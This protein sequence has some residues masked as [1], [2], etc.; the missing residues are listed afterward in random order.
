MRARPDRPADQSFNTP[1][2]REHTSNPSDVTEPIAEWSSWTRRCGS[3]HLTLPTTRIAS[4]CRSRSFCSFPCAQLRVLACRAVPRYSVSIFRPSHCGQ[5]CAL[6]KPGKN[7]GFRGDERTVQSGMEV[8]YVLAAAMITESEDGPWKT[9][10]IDMIRDVP[11]NG[12]FHDVRKVRDKFLGCW[13]SAVSER[14]W[15]RFH[16]NHVVGRPSESGRLTYTR[17]TR[18]FEP[19]GWYHPG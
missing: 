5:S 17:K 9:S 19:H 11:H 3:C 1:Q 18:P 2:Y 13:L 12:S 8:D 10:N 4:P 14:A 7:G 16:R 6:E 15:A